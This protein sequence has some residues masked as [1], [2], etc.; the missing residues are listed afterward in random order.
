MA[1]AGPAEQ[2]D[3]ENGEEEIK[4][5]E[6]LIEWGTEKIT[7]ELHESQ[8]LADIQTLLEVETEVPVGKQKILGLKT[9]SK[10]AITATTLVSDLKARK[11][12]FKMVGS[13]VELKTREDFDDIPQIINDLDWDFVPDYSKMNAQNSKYQKKLDHLVKNSEINIINQPRQGKKLLVLDLDNT[14]FDM[15]GMRKTHDQISLKRP[16]T[17]EF[18]RRLYPHYDFVIWS[19]TRWQWIEIKLTEL[20]IIPNFNITFILDK[21]QMPRICSVTTRGMQTHQIKPLELIWRRFPDH[22]GPHN[23]IHVDDL[24][25]NFAYNPQN[26]LKC[27]A[28]RNSKKMKHTDTELRDL[29]EYFLLIAKLD[30][31][32]GLNHNKWR[33]YLQKKNR[34]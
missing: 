14:L 29:T 9:R 34:Q 2:M 33:K 20:C 26:G 10:S 6:W 23:T 16:Y 31:F 22:Y 28:Y 17:D 12:K 32:K 25:R 24:G 3:V 27:T 7:L 30:T 8:T 11:N 4:L 18:L 13:S 1:D 21:T 15:K 5:S 19:Q